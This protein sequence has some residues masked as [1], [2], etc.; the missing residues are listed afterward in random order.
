[1]SRFSQIQRRAKTIKEPIEILKD[2]SKIICQL[3]KNG[4]F[5]FYKIRKGESVKFQIP[6]LTA[7]ESL[8]EE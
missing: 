3:A 6:K 7:K 4:Q 1:M 2:G 8:N 5:K